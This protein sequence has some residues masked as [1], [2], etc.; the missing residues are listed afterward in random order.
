VF[1]SARSLA[2]RW[3]FWMDLNPLT[4]VIE[5]LRL[6]VFTGA[7]PDWAQWSASLALGCAVAL[8]GAWFFS[9][10]RNGFADVL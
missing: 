7:M 6:V 2:P 9:K 8:A 1:Y 3:Q 10:T 5:N 4:P